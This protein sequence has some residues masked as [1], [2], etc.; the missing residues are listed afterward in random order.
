MRAATE[1]VLVRSDG[2]AIAVDLLDLVPEK[3]L[4]VGQEHLEKGV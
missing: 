4:Q 2:E 1:R 3:V